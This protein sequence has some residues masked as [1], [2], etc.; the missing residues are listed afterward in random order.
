MQITCYLVLFIGSAWLIVG[1]T[2]RR[3]VVAVAL[4][5]AMVLTLVGS[6]QPARAQAPG[7]ILSAIQ[8]VLGV[9]HGLIQTALT[10]INTARA[11]L[12]NL[13]QV[14][15]W[16]QQ[17][18]NQARVQV[19]AI[20]GQYRNLMAGIIHIN[21]RSATLPIPQAFEAVVRDHQ[22]NNFSTLATAYGNNYGLVPAASDA[23]STDRAMSDMDDA[24]ALDSL[25][26]LKASDQATDI[27]MQSADSLENAA[28]QA[29][30]GSTPF[31]TATAIVSS[32]SSQALTQKMLAAELR[33]EAARLAHRNTVRKEYAN[34]TTQLRGVLVNLLQHH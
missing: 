21:L 5:G 30:P 26:L 23:S 22:V 1:A 27:E 15:V 20:T 31:L 11:A 17:L 4:V 34:N 6:P 16:P 29:A 10:S 32:I 3:K 24:L 7:G 9:I 13:H 18:I 25:K 19:T 14:T 8:A 28:G 12:R 33:Q 2:S